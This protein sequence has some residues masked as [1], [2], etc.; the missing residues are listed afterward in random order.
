MPL[1]HAIESKGLNLGIQQVQI[2]A[3]IDWEKG[4]WKK[5]VLTIQ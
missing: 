5:I 3:D 4:V 2:E 1:L